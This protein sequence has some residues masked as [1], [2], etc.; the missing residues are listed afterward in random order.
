MKVELQE[1]MN[2]L[3]V[4]YI[5]S[6]YESCPWSYY[7]SDK[8][9]TCSAEIRMGAGSDE[10]EGEI[11]LMHDEPDESTPPME[12]I[13]YLVAKPSSDGMWN[14]TSLKLMGEPIDEE[15]YNWEEKSCDFFA[16]VVQELKSNSL[17]DI[18]ELIETIIHRRERMNDQYGGGGG[19]SPKV[20]GNLT[21]MKKG[22]F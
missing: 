1:L 11:Q 22:G 21:G 4:G 12:H 13:C 17:P 10:L 19:K 14:V 20:K 9:I 15:I 16:A 18:E 6:A 8:G 3:G 2:K 5:P 7:D